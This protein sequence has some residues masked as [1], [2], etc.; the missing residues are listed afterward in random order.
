MRYC[1]ALCLLACCLAATARPLIYLRH[2]AQAGDPHYAY[3]QS[4]L[5][6]A[7]RESGADYQPRPSE[8]VMV[9]SR[10]LDEMRRN[11][12][13][14][15]LVWT[16]TSV[17]RER[18]LLPVRIPLDRGLLGW[19]VGLV[20]RARIGLFGGVNNLADLKAFEAGQMH[21]W[22]DTAIL[23]D[24]GLKVATT[25]QY[26]S[27][28]RML[29][30]DR[31]DYFPRSLIEVKDEWSTHRD[32]DLAI[33]PAVLIRYPTAMYFFVSR[34]RPELARA[35]ETGLEKAVKKGSLQALFRQ[36]YSGTLKELD[37]AGRRVIEL[38]N[39]LLPAATPLNR[40]ELW[41]RPGE[42]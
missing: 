17:E 13:I 35:L 39:P 22:P 6:L 7:I 15:D 9:Q 21:D 1:L 20:R 32:L 27:L 12:G 23:R 11:S 24:N 26:E 30:A 29:A 14:V 2:Q 28:F 41:Y 34:Q 42:P 18:E 33:E 31:F 3:M 40:A 5:D 37:V 16:M 8:M 4:V 38:R 19:R 10:A 25:D 36:A